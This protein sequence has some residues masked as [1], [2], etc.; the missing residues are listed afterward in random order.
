MDR[1][2]KLD[3]RN[4]ARKWLH[5]ADLADWLDQRAPGWIPL[6]RRHLH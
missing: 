4:V 2:T 3:L 5:L 6:D 1:D